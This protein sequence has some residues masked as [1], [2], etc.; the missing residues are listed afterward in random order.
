MFLAIAFEFSLLLHWESSSLIRFL[1]LL[2]VSNLP[3]HLSLLKWCWR[4]LDFQFSFGIPSVVGVANKLIFLQNKT[5][6]LCLNTSDTMESLLFILSKYKQ[7]RSNSIQMRSKLA[8]CDVPGIHLLLLPVTVSTS[9]DIRI[10]LISAKFGLYLI[11]CLIVFT[12]RWSGVWSEKLKLSELQSHVR[13]QLALL[14]TRLRGPVNADI[15]STV[16]QL[17]RGFWLG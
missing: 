14:D 15:L 8:G 10:E 3:V 12:C 2:F 5:L 4:C 16:Y 13:S 6:L 1:C 17:L 11:L 9:F 7:S